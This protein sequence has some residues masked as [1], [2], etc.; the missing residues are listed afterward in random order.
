MLLL[1]FAC[2][3]STPV[4]SRPPKEGGRDSGASDTDD[5]VDTDTEDTDTVDTDT[6][7]VDTDTATEDTDTEEPVETWPKACPD[8]YD[9]DTVPTFELQ[10]RDGELQALRADCAAGSQ[11]Y[12]PVAFTYDGETVDAMVR[13]K[14]NW[15]WSCDKLQFVV[16]FNEEDP[17]GRFHGQRKV[18]LDAPWYDR[19]LMHE[20][21]AFPLFEQ[22]GL[23]YSCVNNAK[24]V[25]NGDYYGL[26]ANIER[27]DKEYLERHFEEPDGNLYQG[28]TE[29]KTNE[30]VG[31][32]TNLVALQAATT[33]EEIAALMDLDQA[34]AEWATE[35]M[36]PAMDN[37]WAG[38]EINYYLYDHPTRGFVYLP[39]DLDLSFGDA[40][41]TNG[42]PVWPDAV[43]S[44]PIL[45]EHSGWQKEALVERVLS[46]RAWCERF[47][48]EL[49]LSRAAYSPED[50]QGRLDAWEAQI[51]E[52]VE[53]DPNKVGSMADHEAAVAE[54][55]AFFVER[56]AY[57]DDWLASGDHCPARF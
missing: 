26:Y 2:V 40:A 18:M 45:Y 39:Y 53:D 7:T 43:A 38:V 12:H 46:D 51:A 41:Y 10:F 5:T 49:V 23:P 52:A 15:S 13:L 35:A 28:G 27:I 21:I 14:G 1:A 44:D 29:L 11:E 32:T 47:V 30:D 50:M 17:S 56:A 24:V 33:V 34:V 31:D 20:R 4:V 8:L 16:S 42:D 3:S 6:D 55:R 9:P 37:Y 36:L 19:T 57:V 54:L 25:V 22:R 48:E